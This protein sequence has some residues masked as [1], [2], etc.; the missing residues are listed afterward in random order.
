[1]ARSGVVWRCLNTITRTLAIAN[2]PA[3]TVADI[4]EAARGIE[5]PCHRG[6]LP[7]NDSGE[8]LPVANTA[9]S[10]Y[11]RFDVTDRPGVIAEIAKSLADHG[12]GISGTHSPVNPDDPDADFVDVVFLLHKC[13]FGKLQ[14]A[15][16]AIEQLDCVNSAPVVFRIE[17]LD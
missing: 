11:V 8:V 4:V 6:F 3:I 7:Y 2:C 10:Y 16:E 12:I 14:T 15:L 13:P 1:M 9:T 5:S 17:K